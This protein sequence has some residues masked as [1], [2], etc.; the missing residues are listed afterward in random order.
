MIRGLKGQLIVSC[1]AV[2]K[3]PFFSPDSMA[4]FA[5]AARDGGAAGIR[6]NSPE[7]IR[8]IRNAVGLPVIGIQKRMMDD[9]RILIT[10]TVEDAAALVQAGAIA[11]AVDCTRRGQRY[12][13]LERLA[14]I[15][16]KFEVEVLADIATEDE[17]VYAEAAGADY[18]LTTMRGFTVDTTH[19]RRFEPE[20]VARLVRRLGTPVIA[21]GRIHSPEQARTA[22]EAGAFAVVVGGAITKPKEITQRF[23]TSMRGDAKPRTVVGVDLGGTNTKAGA[24]RSNGELVQAFAVPTPARATQLD[25]LDHLEKQVRR[26]MEAAGEPVSAVGIATAGWVDPATGTVVHATGNLPFWTGAPIAAALQQVLRLPVYVENDANAFALAEGRFGAAAGA[27]SYVG[28]TVGT[29]LG[30]GVVMERRLLRGAHHL[31][32]ALGHMVVEPDGLPCTCGQKGCLEVYV[33]SAALAR[34]E[35]SLEKLAEYLARGCAAVVHAYDPSVLVIGGGLAVNNERLF[36]LLRE[37]LPELV[38]AWER[39]GTKVMASGLGY[40]AGVMG[41][42]AVALEG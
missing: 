39:R 22:L 27:S 3:E 31:A 6:A 36:E 37:R 30:A 23:V 42:A 5:R 33:N 40:E 32:N 10:P 9:G 14:R 7:D 19:V 24:V 15:K 28:L 34:Y 18:I 17:A 13:A 29:G 26:A 11:I 8:A 1:Q 2:E 16:K 25:L 38:F 12:G 41:A 35:G 21:E 20:F 4:R